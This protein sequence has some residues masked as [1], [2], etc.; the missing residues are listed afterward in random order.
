MKKII[1]LILSIFLLFPLNIYPWG[2][3]DSLPSGNDGEILQYSVIPAGNE[4]DIFELVYGG[5]DYTDAWGGFDATPPM[6]IVFIIGNPQAIDE[7]DEFLTDLVGSENLHC[8]LFEHESGGTNYSSAIITAPTW[9]YLTSSAP[10]TIA[11]AET[12]FDNIGQPAVVV[13]NVKENF[14]TGN[15]AGQDFTYNGVSGFENDSVTLK[16]GSNVPRLDYVASVEEWGADEVNINSY[17][18]TFVG[19]PPADGSPLIFTEEDTVNVWTASERGQIEWNGNDYQDDPLQES[20]EQGYAI[21]LGHDNPG[22]MFI[23]EEDTIL[24]V[25]GNV[26]FSIANFNVALVDMGSGVYSTM[27]ANEELFIDN[28][29]SEDTTGVAAMLSAFGAP[30]D[31]VDNFK[32][33]IFTGNGDGNDFTWTGLSGFENSSPAPTLIS[34]PYP[35]ISDLEIDLPEGFTNFRGLYRDED[36]GDMVFSL[37]DSRLIVDNDFIVGDETN[38]ITIS[39]NMQASTSDGTP[40]TAYIYSIEEDGIKMF[41][42]YIVAK[43][44]DLS[45][46]ALYILTA[47]FKNDGGSVTQVGGTYKVVFESEATWDANFNVDG[48]DINLDITGT[49]GADIGWNYQT[50]TMSFESEGGP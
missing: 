9:D 24:P 48:S 47:L 12:L 30:F 40:S 7:V 17:P 37:F 8:M 23:F 27:Y 44:D 21:L 18:I 50:R 41:R 32:E 45:N 20:M 13:N 3:G 14:F 34:Q 10:V 2:G 25:D 35:A 11:N 49:T 5:E 16:G 38:G 36:S 4:S 26:N 1:N 29:F 6:V 42:T 28:G 31:S 43:Q 46:A 33:D 19:D 39:I 15:G 22:P